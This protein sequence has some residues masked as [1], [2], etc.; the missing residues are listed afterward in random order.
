MY[1]CDEIENKST[2]TLVTYVIKPLYFYI[3]H[4]LEYCKEWGGGALW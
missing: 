1:I 3:L 2:T 4:I